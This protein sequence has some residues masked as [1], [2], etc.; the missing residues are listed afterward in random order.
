MLHPK[1]Q[2]NGAMWLMSNTQTSNVVCH[3][4]M[5]RVLLPGKWRAII[6]Q[7]ANLTN[8]AEQPYGVPSQEAHEQR[9]VVNENLKRAT[10]L[11][12]TGHVV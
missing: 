10:V 11:R 3:H 6:D 1:L 8:G 7:C 9:M 4:S 5:L 2:C 12:N